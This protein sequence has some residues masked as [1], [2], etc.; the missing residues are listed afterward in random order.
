M[1]PWTQGLEA[2]WEG[3]DF[4]VSYPFAI[5]LHSP[6]G[7]PKGIPGSSVGRHS[8]NC[9]VRARRFTPSKHSN[10]VPFTILALSAAVRICEFIGHRRRSSVR[11]LLLP[12]RSEERRVDQQR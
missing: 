6:E 3:A 10:S 2:W 9:A 4:F 7:R 5:R 8:R 12:I 1:G 11:K